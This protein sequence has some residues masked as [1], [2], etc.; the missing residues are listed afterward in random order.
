MGHRLS[1]IYT[2]TGDAGETGLGDGSRVPKDSLRIEAIG[3]VDELNTAVGTLIAHKP[4]AAVRDALI[5]IQHSLFDL[6]S[7]LSVPGYSAMAPKYC[8]ATTTSSAGSGSTKL[9]RL[10]QVAVDRLRDARKAT[11]LRDCLPRRAAE[12]RDRLR[13]ALLRRRLVAS[14]PQRASTRFHRIISRATPRRRT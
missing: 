10:V 3:D 6:G 14:G 2:R 4:R 1:K 13:T 7:E 5:E 11:C 8:S 12:L 9:N